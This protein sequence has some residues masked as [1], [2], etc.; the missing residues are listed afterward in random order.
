MN[1]SQEFR[2][3][4]EEIV[5]VVRWNDDGSA[6]IVC[7]GANLH[8]GGGSP[9]MFWSEPPHISCFHESCKSDVA[10]VNR[11]MAMLEGE[12]VEK[13]EATPEQKRHWRRMR[14]LHECARLYL[15]PKLNPVTIAEWAALSPVNLADLS[16]KEQFCAFLS[17]LYP[18]EPCTLGSHA[19]DYLD[20]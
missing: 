8:H 10:Q 9:A 7:P 20:R 13:R 12:V 1:H 3:A 19:C 5:E 6:V 16:P 15:R 18:Q 11:E 17:A 2:R 14:R 4:V